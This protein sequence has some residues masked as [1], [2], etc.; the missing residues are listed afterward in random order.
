[1]YFLL[2]LTHIKWVCMTACQASSP[3]VN[4]IYDLL[5]AWSPPSEIHHMAFRYQWTCFKYHNM[6]VQVHNCWQH[7]S[8][9]EE[10]LPLCLLL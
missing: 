1:M 8:V 6:R 4:Q 10:T 2:K 3:L 7:L 5:V 9:T